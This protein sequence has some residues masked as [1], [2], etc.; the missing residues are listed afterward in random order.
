MD[1]IFRPLKRHAAEGAQIPTLPFT[2]CWVT[3]GSDFDLSF[4]ICKTVTIPANVLRTFYVPGA[5]R[6][7]IA[8]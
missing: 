8:P 3:S 7:K 2:I 5:S 6:S 1:M 4:L